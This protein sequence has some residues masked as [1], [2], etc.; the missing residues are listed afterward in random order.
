MCAFGPILTR[1]IES[2]PP[3]AA[4][5]DRRLTPPLSKLPEDPK[6]PPTTQETL[7][8]M[9]LSI[10]ALIGSMAVAQAEIR[11]GPVDQTHGFPLWYEDDT[12][13]RLSL[14]TDE[15]AGCFFETPDPTLPVSFPDNFAD[16]AF[17]WAAEAFMFGDG[18]RRRAILV[19]A[20]EGAFD[21][22]VV[23]HG[24]QV[25]FSR[26]RFFIDGIPEMVGNTYEI[27]YPY[28]TYTFTSTPGDAGPGVH[29][30][31]H[32]DTADVGR[33]PLSFDLA[34]AEFPTFLIP[35]AMD[36]EQ[37]KNSPGAFMMDPI[38]AS[39]R[40]EGSPTGNNF[41]RIEGTDIGLAYPGFRCADA[42][43]GPDPVDTNDCVETDMFSIMGEVAWRFGA[44]IDQAIY[45]KVDQGT[46][47]A[48]DPRTYIDV[49]L[50]T[51]EG[52][53]LAVSVDGGPRQTYVPTDIG[54]KY[55]VR[56]E[57][58][59][60]FTLPAGQQKP[61]QIEVANSTDDPVFTQTAPV[62][63]RVV[64]TRA[65]YDT[66]TGTMQIAA[67]T[68][69]AVDVSDL[70]IDFEPAISAMQGSWVNG[71]GSGWGAYNKADPQAPHVPPMQVRVVSAD[72]GS[73]EAQVAVTGN[74]GLFDGCPF[75]LSDA[76]GDGICSDE[77]NCSL[78]ANED[79]LDSDGDGL[80]DAC[81]NCRFV[82]NS[83]TSSTGGGDDQRDS[84]ED[85][86]GDICDADF[87][88]DG[89]VN[90]GDLAI[91]RA[92]FSS[93]EA[94]HT[95]MNG[96]GVCNFAE[97]LLFQKYLFKDVGADVR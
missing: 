16:E 24:N 65:E 75:D 23:A 61:A 20:R 68:T 69:N 41:F 7:R 12:G 71:N 34:L 9:A 43:L 37:L 88:N 51:I 97:V 60:D 80:G 40:L 72:G 15:A 11:V 66:D 30:E 50:N 49:W 81:D 18:G 45:G 85:G 77:D 44:Q 38:P 39:T 35:E 25:V 6:M 63:D 27:T 59:V 74:A 31:G 57:E 96:D 47:E 21:P 2:K 86:H 5:G 4:V 48:P 10:V 87:N 84:D 28:G 93:T 73:D 91:L 94:T 56:L 79:Q 90:F 83:S 95:D 89:V 29:G 1:I 3:S 53:S 8:A 54:G 19:M 13:L 42:T 82:A 36:R 26:T 14:C 32:S 67:T 46:A 22:E 78:V 17:Y 33:I 62:A 52:Q 64:I 70:S 55:F 92:E 76:D 58:G